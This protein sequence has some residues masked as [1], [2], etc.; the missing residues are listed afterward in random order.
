MTPT[1]S[2]VARNPAT[3]SENRIHA[4]EVARLHG[5]R[6]GLVPGVTVYGYIVTGLLGLPGFGEDWVDRGEASVRFRSPCYDGDDVAVALTEPP[7]PAATPAGSGLTVGFEVLVGDTKCVTGHASVPAEAEAPP[8]R[9]VPWAAGP[10]PEREQR[11]P[12]SESALAAGTVLGTIGLRTDPEAVALYLDRIGAP[13]LAGRD[14]IHPGMLLE[15]ANWVLSSNV[16]LPPWIHAG[17]EIRHYRS[18][19]VGEPVE[20]AARVEREWL[21]DRGH[22]FVELDVAWTAGTELVAT[23]RHVAIWQLAGSA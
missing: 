19:A 2:T 20:V 9:S 11:P 21:H 13:E 3:D 4:D 8:G 23:G 10:A 16:V 12:A 14:A 18:V 5:F 22:R 6:G 15:G 7:A 17:S 1:Y